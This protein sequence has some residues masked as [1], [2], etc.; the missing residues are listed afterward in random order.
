[1]QQN[2]RAAR[3][4]TTSLRAVAIIAVACAVAATVLIM[5]RG[6]GGGASA[7]DEVAAGIPQHRSGHSTTAGGAGAAGQNA[8]SPD[9]A[10]V[11]S[12]ASGPQPVTEVDKTFLVKV[13][14]AGLWEIPAGRLAQTHASSEAVKRAG[15]HLMDGH[16]ALDQLVREDAE[17][18]GVDIP[19]EAT[20]EQQGFVEQLENARGEEFDR[21]FANLLRSSHG[22]IFATIGEVRASTQND[23]I[24]RHAREAN[25][26]VLDHLEVLE[27]TG[28]VATETFEEVEAAV[29]PK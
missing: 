28:L 11:P 7:A 26:T 12:D 13:R 3:P 16:S 10:Q 8:A 15:L 23:L 25:Q 19:N 20:E 1:M 14:Q 29:A 17:I 6:S 2:R 5:I 27:D 21:L 9:G 22:K 18:L 24:R 4:R